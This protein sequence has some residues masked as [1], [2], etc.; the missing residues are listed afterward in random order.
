M[1]VRRVVGGSQGETMKL[2]F[3]QWLGVALL[4]IGVIVWVWNRGD[5]QPA[6]S[7]NA[8]TRSAG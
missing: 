2:N 4:I 8:T 5:E 7:D 1:L 6:P 3:W